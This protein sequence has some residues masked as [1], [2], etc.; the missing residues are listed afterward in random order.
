MGKHFFTFSKFFLAFFFLLSGQSQEAKASHAMGAD[1]TYECL[2]PNQYR[3]TY[4]FYRDCFG[5]DAPDSVR[6]N[7]TST[8]FGG[9]DLYLTPNPGSPNR[10]SATCDGVATTC[11]GGTYTG[12]EEW[13]YSGIVNL[14]GPCADWKFSYGECCRNSA[15]TTLASAASNDLYVYSLLNSVD[16]PCNNSPTFSNKPVPFACVG[17]RFCFNHG[18]NDIDGDSITYQLITPLDDA[19]TPVTYAWPFSNTQPVVSAPPVI[20]SSISGDI[21][22]VPTQADVTVFAVLVSEYRN[23]VLIGQVERDIQLTVNACNNFLPT[24]TGINGTPFFTK[25]ICANVPFNFWAAT[26]DA[27]LI[28]DTTTVEWDFGIAG[29]NFITTG[30]KRDS[31]FFSWTPTTADISNSPYCFTATVKDNHCPYLGLQVFSFCFT[32][33]GVEADAGPDQ[34]VAC[35]AVANLSGSA[36]SACGSMTYRW[37]PSG[38]AGQ[39]LN[40]VGIGDY[41]LEVTAGVSACKDTDMVSIL[42]GVGAASAN[43]VFSTNCSGLPVQFTD[44]SVGASSWSWDFGDLT[45]SNAQSPSHTF[46]GNGTYTVKLVISSGAGC[47]DSLSLQVVINTNIPV[48]SFSAPDK[49]FGTVSSFTDLSAGTGITGW[50]WNFNDPTSGASNTSSAQNPT[51]NFTLP[52]TYNVT[53]NVTNASGCSH[54]IQQNVVVNANPVIAVANAQICIGKQATLNGPAG[55]ITYVWTPGGGTQT[56][57]VSPL[58]NSAYSLTVTDANTCSGTAVANVVVNPLP[59]A[60]AGVDQTIC[61]GTSANLSGGGAGVGGTYLWNPGAQAGQNVSVS[62]VVSTDY[63]VTATDALGCTNTD[64]LRVNVNPMPSVDAGNDGG[65]CKGENI[66]LSATA[67]GGNYSWAPGGFITSSINVSPAITTTYTVTVSDGIGC[68]GIDL[69]TVFVNPIRVASF[70]KTAPVCV[71]NSVSFN[72]LTAIPSGSVNTWLWTFGNGQ[73]SAVQNPSSV[74]NAAGPFNV[75]LRV[76]SDAGCVD[77]T[78]NILMTC[79]S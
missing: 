22:M 49:C 14:P 69:V 78:S 73:T 21:C 36:I 4:S 43:F 40:G 37:L 68:G 33:C 58:V 44:Q 32:V 34:S 55:Y 59:V 52:G 67:G 11:D 70:S 72:D 74:Y 50:S 1:L 76:T 8:C 20:F 31:A 29:A 9:G 77:S 23:G 47:I 7:Y 38:T 16:A 62:P 10:I 45:T 41:Y 12:I 51:H 39:T 27:D 42:P 18:A 15:I 2:G 79:P 61:E 60:L 30:G 3:L 71:S 19:I 65:I 6:V 25:T 13:I 28:T 53:L 35:G 24:M 66:Q 5:I 56:I 26:I 17:Q 64:M 63:T 46:P 75:N 57:N 54:Q 48:A